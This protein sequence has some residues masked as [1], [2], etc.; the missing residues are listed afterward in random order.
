[1]SR[2]GVLRWRDG[3]NRDGEKARV[4]RACMVRKSF[5][6]MASDDTEAYRRVHADLVAGGVPAGPELVT[7]ADA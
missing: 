1:M 6:W 3:R 7:V 4:R 2:S 5:G